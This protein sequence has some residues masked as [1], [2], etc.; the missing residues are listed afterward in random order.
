MLSSASNNRLLSIFLI[1]LSIGCHTVLAQEMTSYQQPPKVMSDVLLAPPTPW[2]SIDD[3]GTYMILSQAGSYNKVE[4]LAQPELRIAG[5]RINP[6]TFG[7]SRNRFVRSYTIRHLASG[8]ET[9]VSGLPDPLQGSGPV[10]NPSQTRFAVTH[11]RP[12]GIDLYE[13]E[14][15]T[16]VARK[17]N[18]TPLNLVLAGFSYIDDETLLYFTTLASSDAAPVRPMTPQGPVIQES[19]GRS[20]PSRTYQDLIRSPY[21]EALFAFYATSQL[22]ENRHGRESRIGRPAIY[23]SAVPSPD[24]QY[25]LTD[26]IV[27]PFSYLV[28]AYGFPSVV[29][30]TD[31][32]GRSVR[33]LAELPSTENSPSGFDNVQDVARGFNWRADEPASVYWA[34]PLD[35]GLMAT[36]VTHH[37]AVYMLR[38]PFTGEPRELTRTELRYRGIQWGDAHL[39]LV[40]EGLTKK[41][42]VRTSTLDPA[43]GKLAVIIDRST[44]D[45]YSDPGSP[46]FRRNQYDRNV[47]YTVRGGR[48][49]AMRGSGASPDGDL[50]FFSIFDLEAKTNEILWRCEKGFYETV[51]DVVDAETGLLITSRESP[52]V[53][54]NYYLRNLSTGEMKPLTDFRDQQA[55]IREL[56][57]EKIRYTRQD[58][59]EL[60]ATVYL[61]KG[62]DASRDGRLPLFLWAYP[63]EYK[64]ASD[65]GQ[66]RGSQYTFTRVSWGSPVFYALAG[67]AVMDETEFPIIGEGDRRPNDN[68]VEQLVWNAE[69]A[70]QAAYDHG[71]G[72]TTR[73]A[74]GGHSYGAFMTANLLAHSRLFDAGIARSGAYMRTLT[75]FGF[76]NEERTYWEDPELYHRM[77]PFSYADQI[78]DALLLVHGDADNNPGTF[79]LN[80]ERLFNA[81]KGHGGT[82]RYVSLPYE[83]HGYAGEENLLH[84]LW[85]QYQWLEQHVRR[86]GS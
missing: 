81:I 45:R 14:I 6:N 73:A 42:R 56:S 24:R 62:Y 67:Y 49:L 40:Q 70:L 8:R 59:I 16:G 33:I 31:R 25:Y 21:D 86:A 64:Q 48:G 63:R 11:T 26:V 82:V 27:P 57:K 46:V 58:G 77:S 29:S 2:A 65:A 60:T 5:L 4:E 12:D 55:P 80:S 38:A 78:K 13:V 54:P 66:V 71:F 43:S 50:P 32:Q 1:V 37:D 69:A 23:Q 28:P 7:P 20:A 74:V 15:R 34:R 30:V 10:W 52:S 17:V 3:R 18:L 85:E 79:P 53:V 41:Q 76:Q 72:D 39:A 68:F 75:P 61:P 47:L 84:L 44:N 35:G 9:K 36:E 19:A 22:V 51:I 83:S